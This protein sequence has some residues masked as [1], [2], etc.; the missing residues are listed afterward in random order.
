MSNSQEQPPID[1]AHKISAIE[2]Q[3][4]YSP[5]DAGTHPRVKVYEAPPHKDWSTVSEG[6]VS[7]ENTAHRVIPDGA[8][9]QATGVEGSNNRL[10][11][12]R[13]RYEEAMRYL[14]SHAIPTSQRTIMEVYIEKQPKYAK[15]L[16][17]QDNAFEKAR[18]GIR[19][20][21]YTF[22]SYTVEDA[23]KDWS[24]WVAKNDPDL[25]ASAMAAYQDWV[26]AG[27]KHQVD[28]QIVPPT[29]DE[30]MTLRL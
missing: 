3:I 17:E 12:S 4:E 1:H 5:D 14:K 7:H 22:S 24:A 29:W 16:A 19:T 30:D 11:D 15:A 25:K 8:K 21:F 23:Q 18:E 27:K 2:G 13:K 26:V 10:V 6:A 20:D 28:A 9:G